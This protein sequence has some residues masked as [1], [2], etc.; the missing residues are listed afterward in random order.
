MAKNLIYL[1]LF[2]LVL[3]LP[4][5]RMNFQHVDANGEPILLIDNYFSLHDQISAQQDVEQV[6][7]R[8]DV[9]DDVVDAVLLLAEVRIHLLDELGRPTLEQRDLLQVVVPLSL[10]HVLDMEDLIVEISLLEDKTDRYSVRKQGCLTH[11]WLM[12]RAL[13]VSFVLIEL[14]DALLKCLVHIHANLSDHD[15]K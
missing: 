2:D 3:D 6:W 8:A 7:T 12:Q 4:F 1:Q 9:I 15:H 10:L 5:G 13:S 11:L 14:N